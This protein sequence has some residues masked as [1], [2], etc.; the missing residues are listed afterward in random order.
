MSAEPRS[1]IHSLY[2][3]F[4]FWATAVGNV[5]EHYDTALFGFLSP[6]LA[7]T[8]FPKH[9]PVI[10]LVLTYAIIPLGML[11][12]PLGALVFGYLGDFY[13]RRYSLFISL[14]GMGIVSLATGFSPTYAQAG[15]LSALIF[16]VGRLLQNFFASGE[17]SGGAIYILENAPEKQHDFLSGLYHSSTIGGILL[18]SFGVT[19]LCQCNCVETKWRFLYLLGGL[20]IPVGLFLKERSTPFVAEVKKPIK[21]PIRSLLATLRE[22]KKALLLIMVVSGFSYACYTMALVLTN[23][24]VPL[25][26][27]VTKEEMA[28][29]NSFLLIFDFL[30][31]P[32][33]GYLASKISRETLMLA[34]SFG[35]AL[36][37]IPLFN[38]L[39]SATLLTV[40]CVRIALVLFGVAFCAP[41]YSW[42]QQL[43]RQKNRYVTIAFG[44]ALGSQLIGSPTAAISLWIFKSTQLVSSVA[45]YWVFLAIASMAI[46]AICKLA[47]SQEK[48]ASNVV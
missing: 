27:S 15:I 4:S 41:F 21:T 38:M 17:I 18:A 19:W 13:G 5:F 25:V 43:V 22:E 2:K 14:T 32:F 47:P 34:A 24:F 12:R 40:F 45:W 29:L 3:K 36:L 23:G 11:A 37:G 46:V 20:T 39:E 8:L 42:A 28:T 16:Y 6:F 1:L 44:Y 48:R 26:S 10:A 7:P 33:F 9:D 31:L 35:V 30:L